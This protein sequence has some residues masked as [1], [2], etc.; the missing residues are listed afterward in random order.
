MQAT[1]GPAATVRQDGPVTTVDLPHEATFAPTNWST[2]AWRSG[3]IQEYW[4]E[5]VS[6]FLEGPLNRQA[7]QKADPQVVA[8][9]RPG[10]WP[11]RAADPSGAPPSP[12]GTAECVAAAGKPGAMSP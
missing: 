8:E 4:A 5:G 10:S 7:L 2:Y 12:R 6:R 9:V 1:S 11:R 3:K